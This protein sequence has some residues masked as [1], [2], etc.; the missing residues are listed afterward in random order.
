[1]RPDLA[2]EQWDTA[3]QALVELGAE[4]TPLLNR[5]LGSSEEYHREI[6]A[7]SSRGSEPPRKRPRRLCSRC[8]TI[9]PVRSRPAP[10]PPWRRSP[11]TARPSSRS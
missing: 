9:S 7:T 4:A 5:E 2:A 8:S 1:M 11:S 3:Q 10:P 6:A